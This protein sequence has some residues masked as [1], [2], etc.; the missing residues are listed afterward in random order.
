MLVMVALCM[1][2]LLGVMA[3]A[4]DVGL[5]YNTRG[6]AQRAADA[7]ALAGA[8]ALLDGGAIAANAVARAQTY[9]T[10]NQIQHT[11]ITA[12]EVT[13]EL[14]ESN[15]KVRV[16]VSRAE[17][18]TL[19]ARFLG[20]NDVGAIGASA[21]AVATQSGSGKCLKPFALPVKTPHFTFPTDDG[22][23]TLIWEKQNPELV[24]I[25]E[26]AGPAGGGNL[27]PLI[28]SPNC[29]GGAL[30]TVQDEPPFNVP[31]EKVGQVLNGVDDMIKADRNLIYNE[32]EKQ[33]YRDGKVVTDWR[34]SPRVANVAF[35]DPSSP[36][37][38]GKKLD[39][40][41]FVTVFFEEI[42]TVKGEKFVYGRVFRSL[43]VADNCAAVNNCAPST[44]YLRLVK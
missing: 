28:A 18:P 44:M 41:D 37:M 27:A 12:G 25:G 20:I 34:S 36:L 16:S 22:K 29:L 26:A 4:V 7:A 10:G 17:V 32:T 23:R 31:G 21:D 40:A 43:G 8:S 19:F 30:M 38:A 13:T 14:L 24:L 42:T 3:L 9:G 15:R 6:E 39:I 5:I 35:Y 1:L 11:S 2:T 33:F